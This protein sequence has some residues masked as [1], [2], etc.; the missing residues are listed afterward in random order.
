LL[1][2]THDINIVRSIAVMHHGK[3][4]RSGAAAAVLAP[5]FD[6]ATA[7]LLSAVPEMELGWLEHWAAANSA[8]AF[9]TEP[10]A[11]IAARS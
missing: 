6:A 10:V 2:I 9:Q 5:P 3:I 4:V 11:R 8:S 7:R 1:F